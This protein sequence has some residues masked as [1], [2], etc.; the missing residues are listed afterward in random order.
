M[1]ANTIQLK[2]W[3]YYVLDVFHWVCLDRYARNLPADTAP[4][5]YTCPA[6]QDCI[7]PPENLVSPVAGK[8]IFVFGNS[9]L[10]NCKY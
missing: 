3:P 4:A 1:L 2:Y 10:V 5:G 6:C 8:L 9:P 7:F